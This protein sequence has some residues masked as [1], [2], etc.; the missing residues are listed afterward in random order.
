MDDRWKAYREAEAARAGRRREQMRTELLPAL[1]AAGVEGVEVEYLGDADSDNGTDPALWVEHVRPEGVALPPAVRQAVAEAVEDLL[2]AH[3]DGWR[4]ARSQGTAAVDV[5][6]G[7]VRFDHHVLE[8]RP[9]PF[10][11]SLGG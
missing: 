6:G 1:A 4:S 10:Q 2:D 3:E 7:M 9:D 8:L 11:V 5:A